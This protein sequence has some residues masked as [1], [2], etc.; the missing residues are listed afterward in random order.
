M[1]AQCAPLLTR[2]ANV[3]ARRPD[4]VAIRFANGV[5]SYQELLEGIAATASGLAA[6][7]VRPGDRVAVLAAVEERVPELLLGIW[8][9]GATYVPL[10][11][12]LPTAGARAAL[13]ATGAALL[14]HGDDMPVPGVRSGAVPLGRL[15]R[16]AARAPLE[17]LPCPGPAYLISTSGTTGAPKYIATSHE[18][19][20]WSLTA[21][22][23]RIGLGPQDVLLARTSLSFDPHTVELLLPLTVG[24]SIVTV[25]AIDSRDPAALAA[26]MAAHRVTVA[27]GTPSFW[28]LMLT[29][30][31]MHRRSLTVLCGGEALTVDLLGR[32]LARGTEVWNVY[33][34]TETTVWAGAVR[35]TAN[36]GPVVGGPLAGSRWTVRDDAGAAVADGTTGE[37]WITG[38]G[39]SPGYLDRH[40]ETRRAFVGSVDGSRS[41]RT[42]DQ[43]R[44]RPSGDYDF[45][46]RL[47]GQVKL[48]GRRIELE[49][50]AAALADGPGVDAVVALVTPGDRLRA[51]VATSQP[52]QLRV[53]NAV[54]AL[55]R[56]RLAADDR[57]VEYVVVA[58]LPLG[59]T[60][61][62]DRGALLATEPFRP[63]GVA[64]DLPAAGPTA[65]VL[66]AVTSVLGTPVDEDVELAAAGLDSLGVARLRLRLHE[67]L[68]ADV[69]GA[70]IRSAVRISDLVPFV[71]QAAAGVPPRVG[72]A[73]RVRLPLTPGQRRVLLGP[74]G[75]RRDNVLELLLSTGASR[76]ELVVTGQEVLQS[77]DVFRLE[78]VDRPAGEDPV[79]VIGPRSRVEVEEWGDVAS[80]E[81]LLAELREVPRGVDVIA[82]CFA[83]CVVASAGGRAYLYLAAHHVVA[84]GLSLQVVAALVD[85]RL[86][87]GR[88]I[89]SS[90]TF[91]AWASATRSALAHD[92]DATHWSALAD[93]AA[94]VAAVS[95]DRAQPNGLDEPPLVVT[96]EI[97]APA[98]PE[99]ADRNVHDAVLAAAVHHTAALLGG[100]ALA[101]RVVESG[102]GLRAGI[103][104]SFT[105]GMLSHHHPFVVRRGGTAAETLAA[106]RT[107]TGRAPHLGQSYEWFRVDHPATAPDPT[108]LMLYVNHLPRVSAYRIVRDESHMLRP[109]REI[110][111]RIPGVAVE[112]TALE[113]E[114][115]ARVH[116]NAGTPGDNPAFLR[117][118]VATARELMGR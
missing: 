69:T 76:A 45:S 23:E 85:S 56:V 41:Y 43:V 29:V 71:T 84:D 110:R 8:A 79:Q 112:V 67:R 58:R 113:G 92:D 73:G 27:Q 33:G 101:C 2:I 83:R 12:D 52:D 70:A 47:D 115:R 117:G 34:P 40:D 66:A 90:A 7:S 10:A 86:A 61:K 17:P 13:S 74:D 53:Y 100:R 51:C 37:L 104:D 63:A 26:A 62:L 39:V 108:H 87:S 64:L 81:E 72:E 59:P 82:G 109:V 19:I 107:E 42:G 78:R 111:Q 54:I 97:H 4:G 93:R 38:P 57:P 95:P 3:A 98:K 50:I 28:H 105:V 21:F 48:R 96:H 5:V 88:A 6:H 36:T 75:V 22:G 49:G 103:E 77:A 106:V 31:W 65:A 55:A 91:G 44:R 99:A 20:R 46:G 60:E 94:H 25:P 1:S 118:V 15:T 24:A 32:L 89:P 68:G 14:V 18:N 9:A 114:L 11:H 16:G 35:V 30:P 80:V 102:R 116:I